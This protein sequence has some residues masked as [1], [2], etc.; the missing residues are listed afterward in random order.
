MAAVVLV[1]VAALSA[2]VVMLSNRATPGD[3]GTGSTR[4][5]LGHVGEHVAAL[6]SFADHN[7]GH[8][9]AGSRGYDQSISYFETL[10]AKVGY[11][12][13]RQRF[14]FL[15]TQALEYDLTV[16]GGTHH[17]INVVGYSPSTPAGGTTA[18]LAPVTGTEAKR[19]GCTA[20]SYADAVARGRIALVLNGGC[21]LD[22]KQAVAAGAGATAVIVIN[23]RPGELYGWLWEPETAEIPIGGVSPETG[24]AL[25]GVAER[26]LKVT[27][28]LRSLTEQ[29]STEN[30]LAESTSGDP[31]RTVVSGAHLDS[32]PTGP[33]IN[34]NGIAAAVLLEA[35]LRQATAP[36]PPRNR[37]VFA[38]WSAEEFGM[39]GA[40]H[41]V[42]ALS[43]QERA[44]IGLYLNL[45]MIGGPNRGLFV[46]DSNTPCRS[47]EGD[48]ALA[49]APGR[50]APP[51]S[52]AIRDRFLGAFR[53]TGTEPGTW[54]LDGRSDYAPFAEAG[55]PMGGLFGGSFEGKT[56]EEAARWGGLAGE[57]YDR[58]YHLPCDN[59]DSYDPAKV[60]AH[61]DAFL[62]VF[63]H[64]SNAERPTVSGGGR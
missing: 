58:C 47:A 12:V 59:A 61:A 24:Q 14:G 45:E 28:V 23:D 16:G 8:R 56:A 17:R 57:S 7:D 29:R 11:R 40:K 26:H 13:T 35:A 9:A 48:H 44:N 6:Q 49:L 19:Q 38:F 21:T 1:V 32:V 52:V 34:D 3:S 63:E 64:Y 43:P 22:Q 60:S 39:V 27:M 4:I 2:S 15:Y 5:E 20:E 46:L 41:Y 55:I 30:L 53:A 54:C 37:L 62:R 51:G 18:E 33:G 36:I 31:G 50:G 42:Q 25:L 10:L